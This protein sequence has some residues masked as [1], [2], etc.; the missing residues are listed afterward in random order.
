M[1]TIDTRAAM[2]DL[3]RH[4]GAYRRQIPFAAAQALTDVARQ[5]AAAE[6]AGLAA[7]FDHP[8]PFTLKAFAVRGA[9]KSTL[10]ASVFAKDIQAAYLEPYLDGGV[11]VLG[12][13]AAVLTP[14]KIGLNAYGNIPKGRIAALKGAGGAFVGL[15]GGKYGLWKRGRRG[16]TLLVAFTAPKPVTKRLDYRHI[17]ASVV[18]AALPRAFA[19]ALAKAIATAR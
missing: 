3:T 4:V 9:R 5:V 13:K 18:A 1:I 6:S 8:T 16:L 11:Q 2:T 15:V 19:N 12:S 7:T 10:T 14:V 17:A